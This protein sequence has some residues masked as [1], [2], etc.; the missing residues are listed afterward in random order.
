LVGDC[1]LLTS[2]AGSI[3]GVGNLN[4]NPGYAVDPLRGAWHLNTASFAMDRCGTGLTADLDFVARPQ[5]VLWD[6]GAF[7]AVP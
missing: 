2:G 4:A 6:T 7:E 3:V 1:N 5:G